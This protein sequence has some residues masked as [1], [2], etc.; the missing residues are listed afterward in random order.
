[1][2]MSEVFHL[3]GTIAYRHRFLTRQQ[4]VSALEIQK[5]AQM[6]GEHPFLGDICVQLGYLTP[7]QVEEIIQIQKRANRPLEKLY[8]RI[9]LENKFFNPEHLEHCLDLQKKSKTYA[10]IGYYMLQNK[11]LT[12]EQHKAIL[13]S[14][15]RIRQSGSLSSTSFL[16]D[17]PFSN[18]QY[19]HIALKQGFVT[20]EQIEEFFQKQ[21]KNPFRFLRVDKFLL[22]QR[23]IR[24]EDHISILQA[25]ENLEMLRL[26]S[27]LER[28]PHPI[29]SGQ[30]STREKSLQVVRQKVHQ[31]EKNR[32]CEKDTA[33]QS[34][35]TKVSKE[36]E[37][38]LPHFHIQHRIETGGMSVLY[39][40]QNRQTG[41]EVVIKVLPSFEMARG[42]LSEEIFEDQLLEER[43]EREAKILSLLRHPN[44]V[45][46][47]VQGYNEDFC[48]HVMEY[49][50][51][52]N[53]EELL[54]EVNCL[55]EK[56]ALEIIKSVAMALEEA[57][58]YKILHRDIKPDNILIDTEGQVKI[59]DFGLAKS[60]LPQLQ[61]QAYTPHNLILGTPAYIAPEI[62][63]LISGVEPD[64]R[65][66][67]YSLGISSY[68]MLVGK[69]PYYHESA[70]SLLV[71]HYKEPIPDLRDQ[72]KEISLSTSQLVKKMM[73]KHPEDRFS[74]PT[75]LW[76]AIEK[77]ES[78]L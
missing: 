3:F 73:A 54:L 55:E 16:D 36:L 58:R 24:P 48:F 29:A 21:K 77:L 20:S 47:L 75:E 38:I 13:R 1:M 33:Y 69:L 71:M 12:L 78:P 60:F 70:I 19:A 31:F 11:Y 17:L 30:P 46:S 2:Q 56:W 62:A 57:W 22:Q 66:D 40:A 44:I 6:R 51:G 37:K 67:I 35:Y 74:N 72:R 42:I 25:L 23:Y 15:E 65:A 4:L 27:K 45:Q 61:D 76:Q 5:Q 59:L 52:I 39:K 28:P 34:L 32:F 14:I 18:K 53:L 10:P 26:N 49:V 7:E 68:Y 43:F 9:G 41:Q 8:G 63:G 64:I 50:R